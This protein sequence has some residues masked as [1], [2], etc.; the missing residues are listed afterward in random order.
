M[1]WFWFWYLGGGRGFVGFRAGGGFCGVFYF[2]K[3][4]INLLTLSVS[5]CLVLFFLH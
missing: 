1:F 5:C 2:Q 3:K 4:K